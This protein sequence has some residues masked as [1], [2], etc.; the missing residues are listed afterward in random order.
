MQARKTFRRILTIALTLALAVSSALAAAATAYPFTTVTNDQVNMRRSASSTATVL[1]RLDKGASIEV[2]GA[3]GNYYK[4]SY[5]NRTG[6]VLK[7]Y[8]DLDSAVT[9]EPTIEVVETATGYP[10]ETTTKDSVN[11]REKKSTKSDLIRQIPA[12]ATIS[13]LAVSGSYAQ[14]EYNGKTGYCVKDYI[15]LKQIVK[16]TATPKPTAVPVVTADML[17]GYVTLQKGDTGTNV[18]ALQG[19]LIELGYLSGSVDGKFGSGTEKALIAFQETNEYPATG[20]ADANLQAFL[21]EGKP[22]NSSGKKVQINTLSPLP[23]TTITL[24][25]TGDA[26]VTVQTQLKALGYYTGDV[27]G[28]YDK[29]TRTA[30]KAFQK[31]NGLT[32]DGKAGAET[33]NLLVS[34]NA[35]SRRPRRS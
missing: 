25:K 5:N 30:L 24:N 9:P 19:A 20:V 17:S 22:K 34:G 21:Y 10:Y 15:N 18:R 31:K 3:S 7:Q 6:Y 4:I 1:E 29:A 14:V 33:Q 11:L 26:V 27:T 12:G 8:V 16:A 2:L 13:V 28:T 23:G 32:A 35:L